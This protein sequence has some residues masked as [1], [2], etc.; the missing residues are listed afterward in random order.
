MLSI[1][2]KFKTIQV[3]VPQ[4]QCN[5]NG[6][7][8]AVIQDLTALTESENEDT[9][10]ILYC[11]SFISHCIMQETMQLP[12]I[13]CS[14]VASELSRQR[15]LNKMKLFEILSFFSISNFSI[16]ES[17]NSNVSLRILESLYIFKNKPI[18][19]VCVF[20]VCL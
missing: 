4:R 19:F 2:D 17:S 18:F 10:P 6:E 13:N 12:A 9:I 14:S 11:F 8:T 20:F 16:L 1:L 3:V 5:Y 15:S 7:A